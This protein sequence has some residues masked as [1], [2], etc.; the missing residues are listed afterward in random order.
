MT[1][2]KNAFNQLLLLL[3]NVFLFEAFAQDEISNLRVE[4]LKQVTGPFIRSN[5]IPT[6]SAIPE[7][8]FLDSIWSDLK[9]IFSAPLT[10]RDYV[11]MQLNALELASELKDPLT[12]KPLINA[13]RFKGGYSSEV[14]MKARVTLVQIL[15]AFD[16]MKRRYFIQTLNEDLIAMTNYYDVNGKV[17]EL[18][19]SEVNQM[20]FIIK[21]AKEL[22]NKILNEEIKYTAPN[23]T[24][25]HYREALKAFSTFP[26]E[27]LTS[28]IG[29]FAGDEFYVAL[30]RILGG[31]LVAAKDAL[32]ELPDTIIGI[33][34]LGRYGN[35][36]QELGTNGANILYFIPSATKVA[37]M[38]GR[39]FAER[40][41]MRVPELVEKVTEQTEFVEE[42]EVTNP[43][44]ENI[45]TNNFSEL[46]H[47]EA[48]IAQQTTVPKPKPITSLFSL[49]DK[50]LQNKIR[51]ALR[52][53][54][55]KFYDAMFSG[56]QIGLGIADPWYHKIIKI[57]GAVELMVD[58]KFLRDVSTNTTPGNSLIKQV[59]NVGNSYPIEPKKLA[60]KVG[61]IYMVEVNQVPTITMGV[62]HSIFVFE[63]LAEA[64]AFL[65]TQQ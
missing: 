30:P 9:E 60:V 43:A 16:R 22:D 20:T 45:V 1:L 3:I 23:L 12:F 25:L 48:I 28:T 57:G 32:L 47:E 40:R 8:S 50:K 33:T 36:G 37:K 46:I 61:D 63:N 35:V 14:Q 27:V 49:E 5:T 18:G 44:S 19:K 6:I 39:R 29:L 17:G 64:D 34:T 41:N 21:K 7:K 13:S 2:K 53:P 26:Y 58:Q 52:I 62:T 15:E 38:A 55:D 10:Y 11:N 51:D 54:Y 31:T 65:E 42:I 24:S 4:F 56:Q 59:I